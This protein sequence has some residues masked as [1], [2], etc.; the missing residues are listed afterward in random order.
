[1]DLELLMRPEGGNN[2]PD[3]SVG[4]PKPFAMPPRP[5]GGGS[6]PNSAYK[7]T[8][9]AMVGVLRKIRLEAAPYTDGLTTELA[10]TFLRQEYAWEEL[11]KVSAC[12]EADV[13]FEIARAYAGCEELPAGPIMSPPHPHPCS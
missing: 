8:K 3:E 13:T 2:N 5:A 7:K 12:L 1:M 9:E 10:K 6:G 11:A 4:V